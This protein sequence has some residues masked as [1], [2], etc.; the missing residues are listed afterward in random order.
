M[1]ILILG[2][3]FL[4]KSLDKYLSEGNYSVILISRG[5]R[6][7][8]NF[9][10]LFKEN[11]VREV[12]GLIRPDVVINTIWVTELSVYVDSHLN[13]DYAKVNI[14]LGEICIENGIKH[15]ISFGTSAEYGED[16]GACNSEKTL[17]IPESL[18][19]KSKFNAYRGLTEIYANSNLRFTWVRIFQP[20]GNFQDSSRFIPTLVRNLRHG[21]EIKLRN[22]N[23]QL[24]WISSWDITR[25][26][27]FLLKNEAPVAVDVGTS[28]PVYNFEVLNI[29]AE[30][31][32]VP[33][34][35]I[36][37][38]LS[39]ARGIS[40]FVSGDAFLLKSWEPQLTLPS[41]LQRLVR[42]LEEN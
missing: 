17:C 25:A 6:V 30:C 16:P 36:E 40:R 19:A 23:S 4:G 34:R 37:F 14:K 22:P 7:G 8:G 27:E 13:D 29:I 2:N 28:N 10:D 12:I 39:E 41:G 11:T 24:D 32:G 38:G 31:L 21:I 35:K 3:G 20:Y 5:T 15:F 9:F 42:E 18:Y 1:K 33:S 26:I